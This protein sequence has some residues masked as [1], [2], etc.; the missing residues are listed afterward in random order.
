MQ[1]YKKLHEKSNPFNKNLH[2]YFSISYKNLHEKE[3]RLGEKLFFNQ[4]HLQA[5]LHTSI[6]DP[7]KFLSLS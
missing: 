4:G 2:E 7:C 6:W 5:H 3:R 1:N